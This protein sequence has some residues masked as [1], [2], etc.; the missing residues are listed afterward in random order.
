MRKILYILSFTLIA[1]LVGAIEDVKLGQNYPNPAKELTYVNV[2]FV[3]PEAKFMISN[4]LGKT[5]EV[6]TLTES[7]TVLLDVTNYPDGIY[8]Y[9]LEVNGQKIT[10][11]MTVKK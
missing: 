9:T 1:T 8:F 6:K 5:L 7:G 3:G 2:D 10:K 4:V 11:K